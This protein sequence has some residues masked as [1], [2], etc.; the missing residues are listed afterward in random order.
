MGIDIH[1]LN[2]LRYAKKH[3][4]FGKVITLGRQAIYV[5]E[6]LIRSALS[7]GSAYR[8]DTYC[9][10]LLI[11]YFGA[12]SVDSIDCSSFEKASVIHDLNRPVP[13]ELCGLYDT[14]I[15]AG[16][17]EHIFEVTAVLKNCSRLLKPGGQII[18][19]VPANNFCGHGFWQFSPELFFSLYKDCY[20]NT[21]VFLADLSNTRIWYKVKPPS[22]GQ[23]VNVLSSAPLY[24]LVRT[25]LKDTGFQHDQVQ[26][27]DYFFRWTQPPK[28]VAD[29]R[30]SGLR[31]VKA[32][33]RRHA[34]V[35]RPLAAISHAL[36][37]RK[38]PTPTLKGNPALSKLAIESVLR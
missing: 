32:C 20:D 13:P 1:V 6:S 18:H 27:S 11:D 5:E 10:R 38:I 19:I 22:N 14:V 24:L 7:A 34:L 36:L 23:R 8:N 16:T 26:Q 2:F 28:N 9:E 35:Y 31:G 37:R 30:K 4:G 29:S 15:D 33:L 3:Q 25:V 17:S 12:S 21:E